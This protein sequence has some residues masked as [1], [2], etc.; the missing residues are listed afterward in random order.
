MPE[1]RLIDNEG[2]QIGVLKTPDA[3]A[4]AQERDLDQ[5]EFAFLREDERLV[6]LEHAHLIALIV[7][8]PDLGHANPLVDP[9]RVPLG[10]APVKPARNRH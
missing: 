4:F 5:V 2:N 9:R 8:Q 6:R 3:L 7:D 10:R 1:V